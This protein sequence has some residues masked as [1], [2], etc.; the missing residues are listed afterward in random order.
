MI[1]L[2]LDYPANIAQQLKYGEVDVA[3][4]PVAAIQD[5]PN[6]KI[7]SNYGIAANGNVVSVALFSQ[8]PIDKIKNVILD[9]QS[10]TSVRLTQLLFKEYWNKE[11]NFLPA[12][13]QFIDEI[14]D[15]TAAVIIGDRALINLKRF[16]YHYDLASMW[17]SYT[18]LPFVFA[19]WV[20]NKSLPEDFIVEFDKA[21]ALGLQ[22]LTQIAQDNTV[23]YYDLL[24][25]YKHNIVFKLSEDVKKGLD[26]FLEKIK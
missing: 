6:A 1:E 10:R 3:L 5:I 12:S 15:D 16:K 26:L 7:I 8:V 23:E 22:H 18:S 20:A 14:K 4:I 25:Y 9:Y 2:S 11:V 21:N 17:K 19:A 24:E 13:P